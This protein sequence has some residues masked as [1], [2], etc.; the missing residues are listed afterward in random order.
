MYVESIEGIGTGNAG[1]MSDF[2]R[3][4]VV[5]G[6][7]LTYFPRTRRKNVEKGEKLRKK[8]SKIEHKIERK[9]YT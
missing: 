9:K 4:V 2:M 8:E 6:I 1:V 7:T 3:K 5:W